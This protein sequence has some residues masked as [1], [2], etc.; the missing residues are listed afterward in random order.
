ML[1]LEIIWLILILNPPTKYKKGDLAMNN[2]EIKKII[3]ETINK[4][5][6]LKIFNQIL[7]KKNKN[8]RFINYGNKKEKEIIIINN[9]YNYKI[10][11]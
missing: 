4:M 10:H 2:Q 5:K 1:E 3:E 8:K 11:K 7:N 9:L 6:N